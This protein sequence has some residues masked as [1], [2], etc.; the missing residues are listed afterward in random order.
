MCLDLST[1]VSKCYQ[2]QTT[3]INL[4]KDASYAVYITMSILK[5]FFQEDYVY[6]VIGIL[7]SQNITCCFAEDNINNNN[8]TISN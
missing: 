2:V 8:N 4:M 1:F 7:M 3:S 5:T 6:S